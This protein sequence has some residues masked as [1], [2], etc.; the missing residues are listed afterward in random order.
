MVASSEKNQADDIF[1]LLAHIQHGSSGAFVKLAEKYAP[2]L[3]SEVSR[4]VGS[5]SA[6]DIDDLRQGALV[7]LYR[8]ALAYSGDKGVTF[9][10]FAKICIVNGIA[11]TLRYLNRKNN[12][13]S[14]DAL[15]EEEQPECES[16][17]EDM[18]LDKERFKELKDRIYSV[19]SDMERRIFDLYISG[20]SYAEIADITES[21]KKS[22]DNALRRL[23][24]KLKK[25][26]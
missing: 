12:D 16:D 6:A 19:L 23:K 5:L 3:D 11:D 22:V 10:L 26:I 24:D 4:Y 9:G 1:E 14:M 2:L 25:L 17:P 18:M 15:F 20:Y 13:V 8:A 7:S 21:S